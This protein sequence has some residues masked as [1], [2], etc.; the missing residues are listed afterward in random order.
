L[1]RVGDGFSG[2]VVVVAE[3]F[4]A[5]AWAAAAVAVGEDVAALILFG[6]WRRV[7]HG[8]GPSPVKRVQ[9]LLKKRPASGL[10][11]AGLGLNGKARLVAGPFL[12]SYCFYYIEWGETKIQLGRIYFLACKGCGLLGFRV[13]ISEFGGFR[14]LTCDFWAENAERIFSVPK[15]PLSQFFMSRSTMLCNDIFFI[16]ARCAASP[17]LHCLI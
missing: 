15:S 16:A 3:V 8:W 12:F 14:G 10:P 4:S 7:L 13:L 1:L 5:E 9:S 6:G 2:G 17:V 11:G